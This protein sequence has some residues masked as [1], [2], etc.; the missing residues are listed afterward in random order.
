MY[1]TQPE[2][3]QE[4]VPSLWLIKYLPEGDLQSSGSKIELRHG[5]VIT[6]TYS[7]VPL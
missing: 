3:E 7:A 1:S 6:P 5:E 2:G 4:I